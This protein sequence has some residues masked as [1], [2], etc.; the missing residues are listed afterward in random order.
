MNYNYDKH[1][2]SE[3]LGQR[4]QDIGRNMSEINSSQTFLPLDE[5]EELFKDYTSKEDIV[6]LYD[7]FIQTYVYYYHK[8]EMVDEIPQIINFDF[9]YI[10]IVK[11]YT[12]ALEAANHGREEDNQ[13]DMLGTIL[14]DFTK[15]LKSKSLE[16][17]LNDKFWRDAVL[18]QFSFDDYYDGKNSEIGETGIARGGA[19][20]AYWMVASLALGPFTDLE[21]RGKIIDNLF[22]KV[23]RNL[24]SSHHISS[25]RPLLNAYNIYNEDLS[26]LALYS[27]VVSMAEFLKINK[28]K[29]DPM[30]TISMA[31]SL[32]LA[33]D[34]KNSE[35]GKGK[36]AEHGKI[37]LQA[38]EFYF[39]NYDL[40][41]DVIER[42]EAIAKERKFEGINLLGPVIEKRKIE[43][44]IQEKERNIGN[45][46]MPQILKI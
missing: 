9:K 44:A 27:V 6:K 32:L 8:V 41:I 38:L 43:L 42:I 1:I 46:L 26:T 10:P 11:A 28:I 35:G 7:D 31:Q 25:G 39:L 24:H 15:L 17:N 20:T 16:L 19:Q 36:T 33:V 30:P 2:V 5:I 34:K 13:E 45:T 40:S 29:I 12:K 3:F 37:A 14:L 18:R 22:S 23:L 21:E 4:Y